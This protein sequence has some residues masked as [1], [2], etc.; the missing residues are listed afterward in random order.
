MTNA[1]EDGDSPASTLDDD[2]FALDD[3]VQAADAR[4]VTQPYPSRSAQDEVS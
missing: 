1:P 2:P 4:Q 3:R